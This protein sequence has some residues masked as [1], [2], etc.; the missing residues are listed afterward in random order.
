MRLQR[1]TAPGRQV[2]IL[3]PWLHGRQILPARVGRHSMLADTLGVGPGSG[4]PGSAGSGSAGFGFGGPGSA[5][6]GFGGRALG[7]AARRPVPTAFLAASAASPTL[8]PRAAGDAVPPVRRFLT[9][10]RHADQHS[11]AAPVT[12]T[13]RSATTPFAASPAES[14]PA[15]DA[16]RPTDAPRA[17]DPPRATDVRPLQVLPQAP[18]P[19]V[20]PDIEP[21]DEPFDEEESD[22]P[23]DASE[24]LGAA[25]E[26]LT[27]IDVPPVPAAADAPSP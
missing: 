11:Q 24:S 15:A 8:L 23:F 16:P 22:L 18:A 13:P 26:D 3:T 9:P 2:S 12:L 20:E 17:T 21:L 27:E 5:G 6:S 19:D 1:L 4:A 10:I 7:L 25:A 14:Q